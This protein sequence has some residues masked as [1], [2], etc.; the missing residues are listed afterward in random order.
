M[1]GVALIRENI[2]LHEIRKDF[3]EKY[4]EIGENDTPL[5]C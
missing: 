1:G 5:K 4:S 2:L 3:A